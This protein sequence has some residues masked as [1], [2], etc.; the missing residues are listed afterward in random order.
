MGWNFD[1]K[2]SSETVSGHYEEGITPAEFVSK[3]EENYGN[4]FYQ[5]IYLVVNCIRFSQILAERLH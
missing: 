4:F 3:V 2:L 1:P 5:A